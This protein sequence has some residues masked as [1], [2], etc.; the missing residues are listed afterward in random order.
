MIKYIPLFLMLA[1]CSDFGVP[2]SSYPGAEPDWHTVN[3]Y[4]PEPLDHCV[5]MEAADN[6]L[7]RLCGV[8]P[9]YVQ[10]TKELEVPA[11]TTC[12]NIFARDM[13]PKK[14]PTIIDGQECE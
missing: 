12:I 4:K 14:A 6:S 8:N 11:G 5:V 10:P 2:T 3:T 7:I 9:Y 13:S 1:A